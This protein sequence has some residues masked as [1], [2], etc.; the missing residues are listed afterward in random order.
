MSAPSSGTGK[1][2]NLVKMANQISLFFE[3][4]P[5]RE[6]AL[7]GV[8]NHLQKFWEPRMR[9][10]IVEYQKSGGAGLRDLASEAVRKLAA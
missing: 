10:A 4:Q 1:A 9:N 7:A 8:L 3:T 5:D 6:E 2:D